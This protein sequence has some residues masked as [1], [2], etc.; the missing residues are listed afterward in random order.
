MHLA[1]GFDLAATGQGAPEDTEIVTRLEALDD[2]E[3][4]RRQERTEW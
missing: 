4:R 2:P 3:G 1:R